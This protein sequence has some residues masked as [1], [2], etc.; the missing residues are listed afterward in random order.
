MIT[1]QG[2][3]L[4][5]QGAGLIAATYISLICFAAMLAVLSKKPARRKDAKEVLRILMWRRRDE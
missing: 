5:T 1:Y 3:M 4:A 2:I